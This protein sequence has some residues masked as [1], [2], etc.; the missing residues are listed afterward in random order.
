MFKPLDP[1]PEFPKLEEEV[2]KFWEDNQIFKQTLKATKDKPRFVFFEGPP[3]ANAKPGIHHIEA[4][5]FK[6]LIPRFQTMR[7]KFVLRKAGWDTHG[8]PVELQVEKQ[9]GISGK[10][11]IESIKPTVQ[12]S[13]IE[14]NRL[15]K[16]SVW[17]YKEEWEKLTHRMGF[18]VDM[19]DP[20]VTYHNSYIE[21]VWYL[22]KQ[23]WDKD[24]I[25][26]GHKVVHY[27]PRC[28]TPLSTHEV[29]QGYK[30]VKET[31]V[32]IKFELKDQPKT[33]ILSWTTTPWTLPGNIA[34]AVSADITYVKVKSG[35]E[36]WILAKDR[37]SAISEYQ[38]EVLEEFKGSSLVGLEYRPLFEIKPLQ[39]EKSYKVYPADFVTTTDGTGVVHTAVMYGEEDYQLGEKIGLP[40]V[41][42]VNEQGR[43]FDFVPADLA[44]DFVKDEKTEHK[45][46]DY[47]KEHN[48]LLKTE[49][50][51][52]D[53]PFCWRCGTPLL[54]YA[55]NSWFIRMSKLSEKLLANNEKVN[56]VPDYIKRGRFGE[57]LKDIKDWAISR[58]RYWGTPLPIWECNSC[59]NYQ[60]VGSIAEMNL[61]SNLFYF[62]RH[63]FAASNELN[64][65]SNY[66]EKVE[67]DLTERG[68]K[69]A[70]GLAL[71]LKERGGI[72]M[73]YASDLLR[74]KHTAEIVGKI[75][76]VPVAFDE[77][78]REYNMGIYNGRPVDE[79]MTGSPEKDRWTIA[80]Q[81]G[82][83]YEQL[84]QRAL[85][86]VK[87]LNGK[88]KN[89]R[90][91]VVTHGDLIWL[92][93]QYYEMG[94]DYPNFGDF[95]EVYL[96][97]PDLH[98]PY[99]DEVKLKC[100][101][102]GGES[103]RVPA[104]LDVWFD[105][106]AMPFA[107][108][109]YPFEN[110]DKINGPNQQFPADFISEAI[111]QTRGW[112]YTLLAISTLLDK[113]PAYLNVI[114]LGHLQDEKGQKMSK[115]KGNVIDPW[116]VINVQ[117]IDALRWYMYSVNQPGD[118]K[119]FAIKDLDLIVRKYFLTLWNVLSFFATYANFDNW[120]QDSKKEK[121]S[122]MD[123]WIL[124]R[125][126]QLTN[127]VT[128]SLDSFDVFKASRAIEQFIL[129]LSTWY[130]RRSRT[131]KGP[132]VYQTLYQVLKTLSQLIAPFLP[133][134]SETIWQELRK[135]TDEESVHLSSWPKTRELSSDELK[136]LSDMELAQKIVEQ[137]HAQR[138][139]AAIK[140][141]Q[142]LSKLSYKTLSGSALPQELEA[143]VSDEVNV[144]TL[145]F[146]GKGGAESV[147]LDVSITDELK[148]EGLARELERLV[149]DLRKKTGL[150]VG[151]TVNLSYDTADQNLSLAMALFDKEKTFV[152]KVS[153]EKTEAEPVQID[154]SSIS[155]TITR[156]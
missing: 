122:V 41:H 103:S 15:C 92:L 80:P 64:I 86:F 45:I 74:T 16:S 114:N 18:W 104:V 76:G 108:W 69:E 26:L 62:A 109:H 78:L 35:D 124:L 102:C 88:L 79:L 116:K 67:R 152:H 155:I 85:S 3:T 40:K 137:T 5:A 89:K 87:D 99:I 106:G 9:L 156:T 98:R 61:N 115:S 43:F 54:Y 117:G 11:Q 57:W 153:K 8:L 125:L 90:V 133:F 146:S 36:I 31:S 82:E 112:F 94:R 47:L 23:I 130:V 105:S 27:C 127:L 151:E 140:V 65:A 29:A 139:A 126:Q 21:T 83:T 150:K 58:E 134:L 52:H 48:I 56:W 111:D 149:Q 13:I 142:P 14:F 118:S 120:T 129:E 6:D 154:G 38:F 60:I 132:A 100:E 50:Y 128:E 143:V 123:E 138:K 66:P 144:K 17:Q 33:Y 24:L 141:R 32:Y 39:S 42:T 91:L 1:K 44:G 19:D 37:L 75:L 71:K 131:T 55:R 81:G 145:E 84:Q 4:R 10:K 119:L 107:Q 49:A 77:R 97:L 70:E 68:V 22:L 101:K 96:S 95:F 30:K 20:Y 147:S 12:E 93:K 73:I 148:V 110:Q 2:L 72:D 59:H 28:E 51:E 46:I 113:G 121:G 135:Q 34:L 7:G 25:Y 136:L 63:G 53:Y